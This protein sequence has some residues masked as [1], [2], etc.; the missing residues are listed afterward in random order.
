MKNRI[1]TPV[2]ALAAAFALSACDSLLDVKNPNNL[3]EESVRLP[4]AATAVVNGSER[5]VNDAISTV[6]LPY[7]VPTDEF[8]W[9]GS[10]DAWG[11]LDQGFVGYDENEFTDGAF[12]NMG[13][14]AWMSRE[15]VRIL[16]AHVAEF[17][18]DEEYELGLARAN[19]YAGQMYM[20]IGEIQ[21]DMTFS[22]KQ[23]DG[24][25][26]GPAN[27]YTVLDQAITYLD[28]AVTQFAALGETDY[29]IQA[30]ALRA[31]A[32]MSRAIWDVLNPTAT[33]GG[34]LSWA[35][36]DTDAA[37]VLAAVSG[38]WRFEMTYSST[39][40]DCD[41]CGWVND[42]KENQ[43]D[44]TLVTVDAS[45]DVTG[46]AMNDPV[47]GTTDAAVTRHVAIFK[48]G[49]VTGDPNQYNPLTIVSRRLMLLIRAEHELATNGETAAF[50]GFI[51]DIRA[52]DS[53]T[54]FDAANAAHPDGLAM[55]QHTRRVNTLFMGLR[56]ADMYRW[57]LQ[58]SAPGV[59]WHPNA[60]TV[61]SPGHMLPITLI[62]RRANC[63]LNG[64]C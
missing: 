44:R 14:A 9:V 60:E 29:R 32:K 30:L 41:M 45:Y 24:P 58:P 37:A 2:L 47:T 49:T 28:N 1:T 12:D 16:E 36:A 6:W 15:A 18:G 4:A 51:N 22:D 50:Q 33:V 52:L 7:L 27:M 20:V 8:F 55:L 5:I 54:A 56:L 34:A 40:T 61:Q 21:E 57:G 10:R 35:D 38:D 64:T 63:Y 23:E 46:I 25:P 17:P 3:T 48:G 42:R 53:Q 39:S 59:T 31:R 13:E 19:M 43:I 26:I 11:Q 62:E